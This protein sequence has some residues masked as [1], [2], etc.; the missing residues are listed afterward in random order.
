MRCLNYIGDVISSL[1]MLDPEK[2]D[3]EVIGL[4]YELFFN[5]C[6]DTAP[7]SVASL[8][9]AF[10]GIE[11]VDDESDLEA[12]DS[13]VSRIQIKG[14]TILDSISRILTANKQSPKSIQKL[15]LIIERL[16]KLNTAYCNKYFFDRNNS[17]ASSLFSLLLRF[18]LYSDDYGVQ[19]SVFQ[20]IGTL[21]GRDPLFDLDD[22]E[23]IRLFYQ[24]YIHQLTDAL[25][26]I[27]R[28]PSDETPTSISCPNTDGIL[29]TMELLSAFINIHQSFIHSLL[30]DG[31]ILRNIIRLLE[32]SH[33]AVLRCGGSF[34]VI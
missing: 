11:M 24:N 28:D 3:T 23:F 30:D 31:V 1:R 34:I 6:P 33:S 8:F 22:R 4:V 16:A 27:D 18:L 7:D 15:V 17:L 29:L 5:S 25:Q 14:P 13:I 32:P 21:V 20:T 12:E 2:D 9:Q 10:C 26:A 19:Q